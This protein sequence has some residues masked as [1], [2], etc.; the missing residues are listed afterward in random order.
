MSPTAQPAEYSH[1]ESGVLTSGSQLKARG[2][3][4]KTQIAI[5]KAQETQTQ[6]LIDR[7]ENYNAAQEKIIKSFVSYRQG[8]AITRV[9]TQKY[10]EEIDKRFNPIFGE[11]N[12]L[13]LTNIQLETD[14][15]KLLDFLIAASASLIFS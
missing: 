9:A 11:Q 5:E 4:T 6:N 13:I 1:D 15:K 14:R 7:F 10:G 8:V 12:S 3:I 2:I